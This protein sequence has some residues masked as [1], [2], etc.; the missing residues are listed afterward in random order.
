MKREEFNVII[1]KE[2]DYQSIEPEF[3]WKFQPQL[4]VMH[5]TDQLGIRRLPQ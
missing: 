2:G 4:S 1:T 5:N 3:V